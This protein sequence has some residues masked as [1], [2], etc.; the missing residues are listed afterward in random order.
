MINKHTIFYISKSKWFRENVRIV[1]D[2]MRLGKPIKLHYSVNQSNR[3]FFIKM[4]IACK[5]KTGPINLDDLMIE[6]GYHW[7]GKCHALNSKV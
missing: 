2:L 4:A 5:G 3:R 7:I 1:A 6:K